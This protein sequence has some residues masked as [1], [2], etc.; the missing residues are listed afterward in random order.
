VCGRVDTC[1]ILPLQQFADCAF[2][3]VDGEMCIRIPTCIG[4]G[5]GDAPNGLAGAPECLFVIVAIQLRVRHVSIAMGPAVDGDRQNVASAGKPSRAEHAVELVSDFR[6]EIR[7]RHIEKLGSTGPKL[8]PCVET[9]VGCAR[10]M[11]HMQHHRLGRIAR[12]SIAA[13]ADGKSSATRLWKHR[14]HD[15]GD[16][17]PRP[18]LPVA[19]QDVGIDNVIATSIKPGITVRPPRSIAFGPLALKSLTSAKWLPRILTAETT[20]SRSSMVRT[21]PL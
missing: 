5:N 14:S 6:F 10:H 1:P 7:E 17:E 16:L 11:H 3:L 18:G 2:G 21:F 8:R 20:P 19:Y 15:I 9:C 12:I 13:E 4:I